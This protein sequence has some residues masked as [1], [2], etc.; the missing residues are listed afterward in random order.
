MLSPRRAT[1]EGKGCAE[2]DVTDTELS[3][4]PPAERIKRYRELALDSRRLAQSADDQDRQTILLHIA[5]Q[6]DSLADDL[7]R[8]TQKDWLIE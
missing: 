8:R 1:L 4:L 5:D 6:W 2:Q 7:E 3:R